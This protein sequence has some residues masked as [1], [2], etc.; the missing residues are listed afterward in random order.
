MRFLIVIFAGLFCCPD[1]HAQ[2]YNYYTQEQDY[3]K[4]RIIKINLLSP[5]VR[6]FTGAYEVS[7][8]RETSI[9]LTASLSYFGYFITP[10]YRIYLSDTPA[11]EGFYIAP[12]LRYMNFR[13]EAEAQLGGGLVVGKQGFFKKKV[14]IDAF[15]GP[16]YKTFL[17]DEQLTD[18]GVRAGIT[19]GLNV[20]RRK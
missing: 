2:D 20:A 8:N 12:F 3:F 7:I 5:V 14:T 18:F 19:V 15:L 6:T 17:L 13:D 11:P 4:V 10:E 9:Q 1:G 16:T